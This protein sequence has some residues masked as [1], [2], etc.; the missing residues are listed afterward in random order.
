LIENKLSI[1]SAALIE[2][3]DGFGA[4]VNN[5]TRKSADQSKRLRKRNYWINRLT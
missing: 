3:F 5:F 1:Y 2:L 4:R